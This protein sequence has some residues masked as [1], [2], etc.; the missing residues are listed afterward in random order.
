MANTYCFDLDGTL[1]HTIQGDYEESVPLFDRIRKV[2]QLYQEGNRI[3][4]DT[5]RGSETGLD[6]FT[7]TKDQLDRWGV[8]YHVLRTGTKMAADYYIDD[9]AIVDHEFFGTVAGQMALRLEID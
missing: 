7:V 4:V 2:N 8:M 6:W 5:A 3:I 1:C 9:K